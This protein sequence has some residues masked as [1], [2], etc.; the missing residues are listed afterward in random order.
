MVYDLDWDEDERLDEWQVVLTE[1]EGLSPVLRA[2]I[3]L[4]AWNVLQV[5]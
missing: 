4:D 3:L 5:L 2:I 1:T